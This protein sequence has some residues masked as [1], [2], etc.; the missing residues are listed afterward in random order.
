MIIWKCYTYQ[1]DFH[2]YQKVAEI[3]ST[4][5]FVSICRFYWKYENLIMWKVDGWKTKKS[6]EVDGWKI[7]IWDGKKKKWIESELYVNI[8]LLLWACKLKTS[9]EETQPEGLHNHVVKSSM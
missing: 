9:V 5:A 4:E 1:V 3:M 6:D 7:K 2:T 8:K